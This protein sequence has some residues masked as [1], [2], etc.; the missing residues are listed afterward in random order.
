M[1]IVYIPMFVCEDF[2]VTNP[3]E[4]FEQKKIVLTEKPILL[5]D[6]FVDL[7]GVRERGKVVIWV[8]H[9]DNVFGRLNKKKMVFV[10]R[11]REI[12]FMRV[13]NELLVT[14]DVKWAEGYG[15]LHIPYED[16]FKVE[17]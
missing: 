16:Y 10:Q 5:S 12:H 1:V 6:F 2:Q 14:E 7:A 13:S 8:H 11:G 9:V 3:S 4:V 17:V 15:T